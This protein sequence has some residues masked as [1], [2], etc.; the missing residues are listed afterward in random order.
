M[1]VRGIV[2][3]VVALGLGF[4]ASAEAQIVF[5]TDRAAW[6]SAAG[7]PFFTEDFSGFPVVTPFRT[8][9]VALNGMAIQQEGDR[10]SWNEVDVPPLQFAPNSGSNSGLLLTDFPEGGSS[11]TQVRITFTRLN[12]A[13]GFNSWSGNDGEGA[14]LDVFS[15]TTLLGSKALTNVDSDFLGY[16]LTG[17]ATATSVRFRSD[18]FVP[19][20]IGE[21]FYIDNLAGTTAVPEPSTFALAGLGLLGPAWRRRRCHGLARP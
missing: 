16:V 6:Q 9:P 21:R 17:A 15:G 10:M 4:P 19:G 20:M 5:F 18:R 8:S 11:G 1:R 12:M 2:A 14:V 13:F 7:T 3:A